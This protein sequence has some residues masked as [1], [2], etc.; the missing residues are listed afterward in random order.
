MSF[1]GFVTPGAVFSELTNLV[2]INVPTRNI[3]G[4]IPN[5]TIEEEGTDELTI[6]EHPVERGAAISDHSYKEPARLTMRVGWSNAAAE[7][8]G[9]PNYVIDIY[10]QLLSL[11]VS[12]EVFQVLTGKRLYNNML[13]VALRQTT[14]DTT[15]YAL[16]VVA[17]FREII[18]VQTT[19]TSV[20][21]ITSQKFPQQTGQTENV[22]T[23]QLTPAAVP[24]LPN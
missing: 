15:A 4:I 23:Q 12:G 17:E 21:A 22:G 10:N 3:G 7:A 8:A 9:D 13:M 2:S 14:D 19:A 24:S 18:L 1:P 5:V 16:A 20:P 6:T 11:Q